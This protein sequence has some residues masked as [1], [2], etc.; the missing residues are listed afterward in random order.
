MLKNYKGYYTPLHKNFW[1]LNLLNNENTLN[2]SYIS[3][4][5]KLV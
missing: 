2:K 5:S 3:F 4:M 1:N